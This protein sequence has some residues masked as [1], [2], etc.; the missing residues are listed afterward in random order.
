MDNFIT[1]CDAH[2]SHCAY[3]IVFYFSFQ[4]YVTSFSILSK[5]EC[6]SI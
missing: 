2:L 6:M 1:L 5:T 4:Y 3:K